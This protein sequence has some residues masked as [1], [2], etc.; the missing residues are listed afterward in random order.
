MRLRDACM[1]A[2]LTVLAS[3]CSYTTRGDVADWSRARQ[4]VLV[5]TSGWDATAGS[6][7]R[8]ERDG[9]GW[10]Q[11]GASTP[12]VLGRAGSA[13]GLGLHPVQL[14]GPVKKEGD[15]RAPAGVF[16]IG[17]AFGYPE[18]ANTTLPYLPMGATHYCM[19]VPASPL[20][21]RIVDA[22]IV[23]KA[24]VQGST[25]PMRLDIHNNGDQRYK[26]GFV[27]EHN[28]RAAPGAG[29]C[30]FAHLWKSSASTTAGC[31][32]MDEAA[33]HELLA[34]LRDDA[35]P[36]FVLLPQ[37]EYRRVQAAWNLPANMDL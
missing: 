17:P 11:V 8:Y 19:D 18:S 35:E 33:M 32:A 2:M 20:Y 5:T 26:S 29:S 3:A 6:L 36:V 16:R 7:R 22:D 1:A 25:E 10:E 23:G 28:A 12:V 15:G 30:I 37:A 9:D 34:W 27:I 31:T 14:G 4:L 13:W 21:N 24:A